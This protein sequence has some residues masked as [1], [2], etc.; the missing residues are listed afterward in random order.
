MNHPRVAL[1][2]CA[3]ALAWTVALP[4]AAVA[5]VPGTPH[6]WLN[7]ISDSVSTESG[8]AYDVHLV[9][10]DAGVS[11]EFALSSDRASDLDMA[12]YDPTLSSV[13]ADYDSAMW[14]E[15][16]DGELVVSGETEQSGWHALVVFSES[17]VGTQDYSVSGWFSGD[18]D[19]IPGL[20]LGEDPQWYDQMNTFSDWDDVWYTHLY[21]GDEIQLRLNPSAPSAGFRPSLRVF[22]PDATSVWTDEPVAQSSPAVGST[23][24][25]YTAPVS[26]YYYVDVW[27]GFTDTIESGGF[28]LF[29]TYVRVPCPP[30][31]V[32]RFYAARTNHH[33]YTASEDEKNNTLRMWS[34][35]YRLE[36]V[37]YTINMANPA[38]STPLHRFYNYQN[39]THFYT[40][41]E[42]E[43]ANVLATMR[44]K[45]RYDGPAY[46]V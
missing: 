41:S 16:R 12:L 29:C 34:Q 14:C 27:S 25:S 1:A 28:H 20:P 45:Y 22:G 3:L 23:T 42:A 31:P 35:Y 15:E 10:L 13:E 4:A 44:W 30:V 24:L 40:A 6:N 36:G 46:N 26:G 39:E 43:R 37:A 2:S 32:Y 5:A 11:Y 19:D 38:N 7:D 17:P 18:Y 8:N 21:A 33:F 9:L